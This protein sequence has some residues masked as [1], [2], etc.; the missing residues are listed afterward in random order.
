MLGILAGAALLGYFKGMVWQL[1]WIA[2]IAASSVVSF[3]F[4]S[5]LAPYF[6][7]QSPWNRFAAMLAL[8]VG[9]SLVVWLLF[10]AVSGAIK[11]VHLSAFDQQLGLL[12]GLAKGALLCIIVTFFAVTLAPDY[13]HQIVGSRSGRFVADLIVRADV[14]LP[15]DIHDTVDPFVRQFEQHF[16]DGGASD[17]AMEGNVMAGLAAGQASTFARPQGAGGQSSLQAA[18]NSAAAWANM[19]QGGQGVQQ[20]VGTLP[21]GSAWFVPKAQPQPA[22]QPQLGQPQPAVQR[23]S[24]SAFSK[25]PPPSAYGA[26]AQASY[27]QPP[28]AYQQQPP[29]QYQQQPPQ[30]FPRGAQSPL[31]VR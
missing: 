4:A 8:Y 20:T 23:A 13:R 21:S 18:V 14:Y 3:R 12:L 24:E 25:S 6:G 22:G 10:R 2:G 5:Q 11:S 1:A 31:P 28:Q 7:Q 15:K 27:Q 9:T 16:Q 17:G 29:Q 26:P 30:P 19:D